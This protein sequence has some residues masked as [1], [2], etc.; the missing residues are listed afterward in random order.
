M[1][2]PARLVIGRR[3]VENAFPD[4]YDVLR[5]KRVEPTI[6]EEVKT[7]NDRAE[8]RH[9]NRNNLHEQSSWRANTTT[10]RWPNA[11]TLNLRS[12]NVN[13]V[14][15][16]S[17]ANSSRANS[18][19]YNRNV[20]EQRRNDDDEDAAFYSAYVNSRMSPPDQHVAWGT[21]ASGV[22]GSASEG[23]GAPRLN[24]QDYPPLNYK[25]VQGQ[26]SVDVDATNLKYVAG[27]MRYSSQNN[28][29]NGAGASNHGNGEQLD[30]RNNSGQNDNGG[31]GGTGA[32]TS[33]ANNRQKQTMTNE[34][35]IPRTSASK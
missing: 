27:S 16:S 20:N 3:V 19:G 23:S 18:T 15:S 35:E 7:A 11:A 2:Y 8:A 31:I 14:N 34:R 12:E 30:R 13:T 10:N 24:D 9:Q 25:H 32:A 4:W 6:S 21:G 26:R 28:N 22:S 29:S 5:T 17:N 1:E 33:T